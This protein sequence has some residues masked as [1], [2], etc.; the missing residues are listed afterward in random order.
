MVAQ[1]V[2]RSGARGSALHR[3]G[4]PSGRAQRT[5]P[6]TVRLKIAEKGPPGRA[7][8]ETRASALIQATDILL[9][10]GV[11]RIGPGWACRAKPGSSVGDVPPNPALLSSRGFLAGLPDRRRVAAAVADRVARQRPQKGFE[12]RDRCSCAFT[13]E[14]G[15]HRLICSAIPMIETTARPSAWQPRHP[16]RPHWPHISTPPCV[17]RSNSGG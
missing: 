16:P 13:G 8:G 12:N 9:T 10:H 2:A 6:T 3:L 17:C 14:R 11:H 15:M 7:Y 5:L 1:S 4:K